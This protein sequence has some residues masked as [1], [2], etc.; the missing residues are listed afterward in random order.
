MLTEYAHERTGTDIHP[1]AQIGTHFFIDHGTGVVIGDEA[2]SQPVSASTLATNRAR[3][4]IAG[5]AVITRPPGR[6]VRP[7]SPSAGGGEP[8]AAVDLHDESESIEPALDH[9]HRASAEIR[10]HPD[11]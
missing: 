3:S 8:R 10:R 9:T 4:F 1:G 5:R 7:S 6:S 2:P 11:A